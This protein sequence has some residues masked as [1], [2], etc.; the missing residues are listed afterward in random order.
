MAPMQ[1]ERSIRGAKRGRRSVEGID[2]GMETTQQRIRR[3]SATWRE[4]FLFI[5]LDVIDDLLLLQPVILSAGT[6]E[7]ERGAPIGSH[8]GLV[9]FPRFIGLQV[10]KETFGRLKDEEIDLQ[11]IAQGIQ[12]LKV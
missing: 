5:G 2:A 4:E 9:P 11:D 7:T 1:G 8:R 12:D 10:A 3:R 6:K